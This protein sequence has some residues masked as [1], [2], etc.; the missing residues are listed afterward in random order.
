MRVSATYV[1]LIPARGGSRGILRKNLEKVGDL[2]LLD[3]AVNAAIQSSRISDCIVSSEDDEILANAQKAGATPHRRAIAAASDDARAADVVRDFLARFRGENDRARVV[4]LQPTSPFRTA[5]HLDDAILAL[6]KSGQSSLV[7]VVE[8]PKPPAKAI[9]VDASGL[10]ALASSGGDPGAN[11]QELE[12]I[13][14]PNG[15]IYI[16][17]ISGFEQSDDIPVAGALAHVMGKI[18]SIDVDDQQDL[19]IARGVAA[20]ANI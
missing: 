11:R 3:R 10:V 18:E 4:Y 16:F 5:K 12:S 14:Y 19:I 13:F 7:S 6:E 17:D 20:F 9:S 1:A 8:S 15:A 2:S